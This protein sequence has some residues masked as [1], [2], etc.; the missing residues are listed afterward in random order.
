MG[1]EN[2]R[3]DEGGNYMALGNGSAEHKKDC[4]SVSQLAQDEAWV[5][6]V[7]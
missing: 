2:G 5:V 4:E 7:V 1:E 6:S 3:D